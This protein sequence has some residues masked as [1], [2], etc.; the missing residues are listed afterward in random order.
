MLDG[1]IVNSDYFETFD[2]VIHYNKVISAYLGSGGRKMLNW[3]QLR[4][5]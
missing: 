5:P 3:F 4:Y 2:A 1:A